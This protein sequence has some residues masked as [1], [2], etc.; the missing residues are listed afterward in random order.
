MSNCKTDIGP[1][2]LLCVG[3]RQ[4]PQGGPHTLP[5]GLDA[6]LASRT[7]EIGVPAAN[8][9]PGQNPFPVGSWG[10]LL[11]LNNPLGQEDWAKVERAF[12]RPASV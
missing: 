12:K 2:G 4:G 8:R 5:E 9:I 7:C 6:W 3:T 10:W 1:S 11:G